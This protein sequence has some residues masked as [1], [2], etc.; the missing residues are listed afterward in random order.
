MKGKI[1][2]TGADGMLG[3]S[4]CREALQQGYEV[5][6]MIQPGRN[7]P[8]LDG[9]PLE[10]TPADLLDMDSMERA[11]QGCD[12]IINVAAYTSIWPRRE[13]LHWK[14]NF[15]GVKN[16]VAGSKKHHI[17]GFVQIGTAN[18]FSHGPMDAPGDENTPFL[19]EV[20]KMDYVDSKY[21]AQSFLLEEHEKNGF[22]AVVVNPTF[23]VG[24]FDT[25]PS[26]GK[27]IMELFKG[28]IPGFAS[29]G[30]NFVCSL[31]VAVAAVNA[32]QLG[33]KGECY[34]VGNEN[35]TF[36][37][38]FRKACNVRGIPFKLRRVP[39]V[40]LLLVGAVNSI[41][42]RLFS[43][44]PNLSF[45]MAQLATVEQYYSVEKARK[46]LALPS[47]PIETAIEICLQWWKENNYID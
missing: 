30:K 29:G 8:V 27:M 14:V 47:T 11:V 5:K 36:D 6:A 44:K 39:N 34:I 15:D 26:S 45:S 12:Y 20:F 25:G 23:M 38:Y 4:I 22:P 10:K 17:K 2:I 3:A 18:S 35:L 16:L 32:L 40:L 7:V 9:L 41:F 28:N 1:L 24:P 13:A 46:E 37:A 21:A 42:A 19:S 33:R 31:D 43:K